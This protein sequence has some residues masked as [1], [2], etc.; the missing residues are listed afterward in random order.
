M[1][2]TNVVVIKEQT[3][4]SNTFE[5][6]CFCQLK[7]T[8]NSVFTATNSA[9]CIGAPNMHCLI[10]SIEGSGAVVYKNQSKVQLTQNS[11]FF[12]SMKDMTLIKSTCPRWHFICYWYLIENSEQEYKGVFTDERIDFEKEIKDANELINLMQS[13]SFTKLSIT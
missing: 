9:E 12:G 8:Y 5:N 13:G 1:K 7:N 11:V 6:T 3:F 4:G 2:N 10:F